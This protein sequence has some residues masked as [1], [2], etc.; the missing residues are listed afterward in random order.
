LALALGVRCRARA[1]SGQGL[2]QALKD[3]DDAIR[4]R[5]GAPDALASRGLVRLRLGKDEPAVADFNA[6]L[7]ILPRAPWAL[8]GRGLAEQRKGLTRESDADFAAAAAIS[9][10]IA[11]EAKQAGLAP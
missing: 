4:Y 3:C 1:F 6:A 10:K 2:D 5:P 7:R 11:A 8:W 9:P